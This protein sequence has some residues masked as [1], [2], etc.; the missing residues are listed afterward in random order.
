M[1]AISRKQQAII[2]FIDKYSFEY[3]Y[4]PAIRE[5]AEAMGHKSLQT[6]HGYIERLEEKKI[7]RWNRFQKRT[8]VLTRKGMDQV[9]KKPITMGLL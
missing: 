5:I 6:T 8:I 7:L 4:P 9:T 2:D 3:Q 1:K